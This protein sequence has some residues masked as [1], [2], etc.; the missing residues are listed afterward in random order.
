MARVSHGC[1]DPAMTSSSESLVPVTALWTAA[2][3][4]ADSHHRYWLKA[5]C[6]R[7]VWK[8][9]LLGSINRFDMGIGQPMVTRTLTSLHLNLPGIFAKCELKAAWWFRTN[10]Q[11]F[12]SEFGHK[13]SMPSLN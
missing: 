13:A 1:D 9:P 7:Y 10:H 2:D 3:G 8:G 6:K 5:F 12:W 11:F 4:I